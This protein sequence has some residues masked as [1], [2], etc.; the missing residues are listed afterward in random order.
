MDFDDVAPAEPE[1]PAAFALFE[2]LE[3]DAESDDDEDEVPPPSEVDPDEEPEF[4]LDAARLS[5]R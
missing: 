2:S 1:P 3:D 4:E 5:L